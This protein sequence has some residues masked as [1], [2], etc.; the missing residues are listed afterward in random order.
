MLMVALHVY[1]PEF[2]MR[3]E[4]MLS[5]LNLSVLFRTS[6]R[7]V[8]PETV[9]SS[10]FPSWYQLSWRSGMTTLGFVTVQ[11]RVKSL[12]GAMSLPV[13]VDGETATVRGG[14]ASKYVE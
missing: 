8:T 9:L 1:V 14:S 4:V 6:P 13:Y 10:P 11:E 12:E 2:M 5:V 3:A 7:M